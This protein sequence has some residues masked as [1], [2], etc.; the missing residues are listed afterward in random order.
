MTT[1]KLTIDDDINTLPPLSLHIPLMR[2]VRRWGNETMHE[3]LLLEI[4][5]LEINIIDLNGSIKKLMKNEFNIN[6]DVSQNIIKNDS[7]RGKQ[8]L[9]IIECISN[10]I[11]NLNETDEES[12]K[13]LEYYEN[14]I[15]CDDF[16]FFTTNVKFLVNYDFPI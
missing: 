3:E 12:I 11:I 7:E 14:L 13:V 8:C 1:K 16:E 9:K 10:K 15:K 6:D 4:R 5:E 2:S